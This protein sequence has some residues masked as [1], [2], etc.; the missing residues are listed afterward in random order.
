[1][2]INMTKI[3]INNDQYTTVTRKGNSDDEWD[4]DDTCTSNSIK[5]FTVTGDNEY[6]DLEVP[7]DIERGVAYFLV[8]AIYDTGDSFSRT[9]GQIVYIDMYKSYDKAYRCVDALD[10]HH[11]QQVEI[12]GYRN[13]GKKKVPRDYKEYSCTIQD[14]T[15]K[16][17]QFSVP[18]HGYFESLSSY[19]IELVTMDMP[20]SKKY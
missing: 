5:G 10:K 9:D 4:R 2:V 16:E 6:Y 14:E 18:W 19:N 8:I 20:F 1:M 7:F 13:R 17:Y 15:D 11:Q 12:M 3:R